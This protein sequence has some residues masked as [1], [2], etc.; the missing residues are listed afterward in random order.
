N[1]GSSKLI[2]KNQILGKKID[3]RL[4]NDILQEVIQ[5][6]LFPI[7]EKL[8]ELN[9][10]IINQLRGSEN[11]EKVNKINDILQE[12]IQ[13]KLFPIKEKLIELNEL[14]INQLRGSENTEKVNKIE[15][16]IATFEK[17]LEKIKN[18]E[19]TSM[20]VISQAQQ[21]AEG[22]VEKEESDRSETDTVFL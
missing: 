22:L 10:L 19:K 12:V 7:K 9:E 16:L 17:K 21:L 6:K 8:I 18:D 13:D 20:E 2:Q 11:T 3:P 5:D 14:I 1:R 4:I 15:E